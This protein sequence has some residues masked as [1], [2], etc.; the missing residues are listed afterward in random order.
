MEVTY[1]TE[2]PIT[3]L[4]GEILGHAKRAVYGDQ[5]VEFI[6]TD[7]PT[8]NT[9]CFG[10]AGGIRTL[11]PK[12]IE[13][14]ANA[15]SSLV[16]AF[17]LL[18][19]GQLID[20]PRDWVI[21]PDL[22]WFNNKYDKPLTWDIEHDKERN[23]LCLGVTD[24][25]DTAIFTRHYAHVAKMLQQCYF[26]IGWNVK[27]DSKIVE[28]E[29]GVRIA[30][31]F[32]GMLA[33]HTINIA[34]TGRHRLAQVAQ[35]MLGVE[36]W[37]AGA[38]KWAGTGKNTDYGKIPKD[39]LYEYNAHDVFYTHVLYERLLPLVE[40]DPSFW[41]RMGAA[42]MAQDMETYGVAIDIPYIKE[43]DNEYSEEISQ[44]QARLP[45]G[46]N[47]NSP[48]QL[49]TWLHS[50]GVMV[51]DTSKGT[52]E[53][54]VEHPQIQALLEYR[55][56]AKVKGTY[57]D[58]YL[59]DNRDSIL[60]PTFHIQGT[61]TG[62]LS[63]SNPNAQNVPSSNKI[64]RIFTVRDSD[65]VLVGADYSQ[66][67]LRTLSMLTG[68]KVMQGLFQ[69]GMPDY[70][71]SM[72]PIAFPKLF[73]SVG[74]VEAMRAEDEERVSQL[75]RQLKAV[76]FG[77]SYGR[78]AR[79]IGKSLEMPEEDAQQIIDDI[80][81]GQPQF[82]QWRKDVM[83]AAIDPA[84]R[85]MLTTPFGRKFQS[86]V[87]TWRNK[88]SIQ[89]AALAFLPQSTASDLTLLS[90][91]RLN[92]YIPGQIV[93]LVHDEIIVECHK[94]EADVVA[95]A[96][97]YEMVNTALEVFG[98]TVPFVAESAIGTNWAEAS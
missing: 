7:N 57:V 96:M 68:D 9:L 93:L 98:D 64:R 73:S 67:E 65:N 61:T 95:Q 49:L 24:G 72:T 46:I 10:T 31:W 11:S 89:R 75:R 58:A 44:A 16:Q 36:D 43:L 2:Q 40:D 33:H 69:P 86:E 29:T 23:I 14:S 78:G 60:Y 51:S 6:P 20:R 22:S 21:D 1:H 42:D 77:L 91:V 50:E 34:A 19:Y 63:S 39:T 59:R 84:R 56:A 88:G 52:L 47:P 70:F 87:V 80:M 37:E 45:E 41:L 15:M 25:N 66:A 28:W 4:V 71:D 81:E 90:A 92:R 30:N 27:Y 54:H 3:P 48:K 17:K 62:R 94:S 97:E 8:S 13:A 83:L 85:D 82:A 18:K 38:K 32:D 79:A 76:I 55:K 26:L 53:E 74:D 12:Q 5:P 35:S